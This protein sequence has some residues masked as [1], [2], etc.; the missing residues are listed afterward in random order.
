MR[1]WMIALFVVVDSAIVGTIL[2][3]MVH[4]AWGDLT[5]KYPQRPPT[6]NA[7]CRR[8]QSF[9]LG[10]FNLT[11]AIHVDADE[12]HLH[13]TLVRPLRWLGARPASIPW[14]AMSVAKRSKRWCTVQ[15]GA[16]KLHGPEWC[17]GL[18]EPA[19]DPPGPESGRPTDNA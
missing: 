16:H 11:F 14:S 7:V 5:R 18:A 12:D 13:L 6:S 4:F 3:G 15:V 10:L 2:W 1:W 17:L 19:L 9:R 8:F